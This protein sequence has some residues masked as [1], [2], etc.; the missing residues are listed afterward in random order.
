MLL[1]NLMDCKTEIITGEF[2]INE[3]IIKNYSLDIKIEAGFYSTQ[4]ILYLIEYLN[5]PLTQIKYKI[6]TKKALKPDTFKKFIEYIFDNYDEKEAK[7]LANSY[8]GLLGIKYSRS[9]KG[10]MTSN[11]ETAMCIWTSNIL[12]GNNNI[13][14]ENYS[15]LYLIKEQT[16]SRLFSDHTSIN[17][18]VISQS[19]LKLLQLIDTCSW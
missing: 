11:Y 6:V 9:N 7:L 17:R 14:I 18:F 2:Y 10:F 3:Y 16:I 8:I 12:E 4:L 13:T 1:K 15:D 5:M 19:I